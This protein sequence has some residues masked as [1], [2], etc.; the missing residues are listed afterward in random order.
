MDFALHGVGVEPRVALGDF[1]GRHAVQVGM[2]VVQ[3]VG[4]GGKAVAAGGGEHG[5]AGFAFLV[6]VGVDNQQ[7]GLGMGF[8]VFKRGLL[9]GLVLAVGGGEL[10]KVK[11]VVALRVG[12]GLVVVDVYD[13]GLRVVAL[14]LGDEPGGVGGFAC[15]FVPA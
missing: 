7:I 10:L 8:A 4:F 3:A 5:F 13:S 15:A 12:E 2:E 11:A 1:F 14:E 9:A 6:G